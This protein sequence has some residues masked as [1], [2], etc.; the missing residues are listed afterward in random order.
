[1]PKTATTTADPSNHFRPNDQADPPPVFHKRQLREVPKHPALVVSKVTQREVP[2]G[3]HHLLDTLQGKEDHRDRQAKK[4]QE[5][6]PREGPQ[7]QRNS[8]VDIH[9]EDRLLDRKDQLQVDLRDTRRADRKL[10]DQLP[11][12]QH[13]VVINNLN[14]HVQGFLLHHVHQFLVDFTRLQVE[15]SPHNI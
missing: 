6:I 13:L 14:H 2:N 9:Q 11:E 1:M 10:Q 8:L 7:N 4:D 3:R 12:D 5:G 15:F